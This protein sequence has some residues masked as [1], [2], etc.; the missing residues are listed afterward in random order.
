MSDQ[1]DEFDHKILQ[2]LQMNGRLSNQ[3]LAE[4]VG[5][6]MSQCSRR[7]VALEQKGMIVGYFA[8]LHPE[9][10]RHPIVGMLEIKMTQYSQTVLDQFLHFIAN[11]P[12]IRDVYK[13][14]GS[15][16]YLL[17]VTAEDLAQMSQL[18]NQ[19]ATLDLGI[20]N[21][22]T[23]IVLERVK[24]NHQMMSQS[25]RLAHTKNDERN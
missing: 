3:E 22:H 2:Q 8:Q 18:I 9:A 21:F 10:E 12:M 4:I 20:G 14:T 11:E 23:S 5:L 7:R 15:Y 25:V 1:L 17:K 16:D 24:E 19:F 13:L 6:S